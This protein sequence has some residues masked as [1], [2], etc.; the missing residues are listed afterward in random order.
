[1]QIEDSIQTLQQVLDQH[2]HRGIGFVPTMGKLHQGHLSL[3]EASKSQGLFT[4]VSVFVNPAQFGPNEDLE[5]YPRQPEKDYQLSMDAGADLVWYPSVEDIYPTGSETRVFPGQLS[6][7]LCGISR[8]QFF[9]GICT[10]VLKLFNIIRPKQAFF[11]EKDFQQLAIIRKMAA[12]F[13]LPVEVVGCP[14]IRETDGLAMS[15]RNAYLTP[16]DR[17]LALSLYRAIDTA[18]TAYKDGNR[19]P[20]ALRQ[21]LIEAW[22]KGIELDYMDFR[23]PATLEEVATLQANTRLFLGAWL[24]SIRLIDNAALVA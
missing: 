18:R 4:V 7:K 21:K 19:D 3:M 10:V 1:M 6:Q 9:P 23:D 12:D 2:H 8:P 20:M 14:T 11:G 16:E 13:F 15:S 5:A 22:P 17:P 24:R